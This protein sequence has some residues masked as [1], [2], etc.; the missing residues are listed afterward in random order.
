M[1]SNANNVF[2][3]FQEDIQGIKTCTVN[4][5]FVVLSRTI[6]AY[7][8]NE[9]SGGMSLVQRFS[10]LA[11]L[12]PAKVSVGV[13]RY[14]TGKPHDD[15][16]RIRV[17]CPHFE[18]TMPSY[19]F[20]VLSL[21]SAAKPVL[22]V[23]APCMTDAEHITRLAMSRDAL[24]VATCD[25]SGLTIRVFDCCR[26]GG[27]QLCELRRGGSLPGTVR[28][29]HFSPEADRLC[30]CLGDDRPTVC[31]FDIPLL[32]R[33]VGGDGKSRWDYANGRP[34]DLVGGTW[35]AGATT[36]MKITARVPSG[37]RAAQP[38]PENPHPYTVCGFV[39]GT[40]KDR[41]RLLV[42]AAAVNPR[43]QVFEI[44]LDKSTAVTVTEVTVHDDSNERSADDTTTAGTTDKNLQPNSISQGE[45]LMPDVLVND[46]YYQYY[47]EEESDSE[48]SFVVLSSDDEDSIQDESVNDYSFQEETELIQGVLLKDSPS[49]DHELVPSFL[50][51]DSSSRVK[52]LTLIA[53]EVIQ[54]DLVNDYLPLEDDSSVEYGIFNASSSQEEDISDSHYHLNQLQTPT[55]DHQRSLNVFNSPREQSS[56]EEAV[57][58]P[59][60]TRLAIFYLATSV[61]LAWGF[62]F[63]MIWLLSEN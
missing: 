58:E 26:G 17:A 57:N 19:Y 20:Q 54:D 8:L 33:D 16:D 48:D 10:N 59:T 29:L 31:I 13:L 4:Y 2:N 40:S 53:T 35:T 15:V 7:R 22:Q 11:T 42:G 36:A 37:A 25:Q 6:A 55:D 60:L 23:Q 62:Y 38:V 28:S 50:M 47:E 14:E 39:K 27:V 41:V 61:F 43:F 32:V 51:N 5:V 52:V 56:H 24:T 45:E 30:C 9:K 49:L 12:S 34:Y 21:T 44:D 18:Q 63:A 1:R 3:R 46:S